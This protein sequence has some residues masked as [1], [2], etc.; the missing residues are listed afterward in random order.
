MSHIISGLLWNT[1][2]AGGLAIVV[3]L[4]QQT[5]YLRIRPQVCHELWLLVLVKLISPTF[6][7]IPVSIGF[8]RS[9]QVRNERLAITTFAR[10][11]P[12]KG[13]AEP[14]SAAGGE[15][16]LCATVDVMLT[17]QFAVA[18]SA[19]GSLAL[20]L[21]SLSR[22][23]S[24]GTSCSMPSQPRN[25]SRIEWPWRLGDGRSNVYRP[26]A[27]STERYR[28]SCGGLCEGRKSSCRAD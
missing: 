18:V 13:N 15:E 21:T 26:F 16:T 25:G 24:S 8:A 17:P 5:K 14:I 23:R 10:G 1:C 3:F 7:A 12:T 19:F 20:L 2:L 9:E 22:V 27:W 28:H 6:F 11:T 4:A